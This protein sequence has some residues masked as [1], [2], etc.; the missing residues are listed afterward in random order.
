MRGKGEQWTG[1]VR[2]CAERRAEWGRGPGRSLTK[3]ASRCKRSGDSA[4]PLDSHKLLSCA[5]QWA[6]KVP[7]GRLGLHEKIMGMCGSDLGGIARACQFEASGWQASKRLPARKQIRPS[8]CA[9]CRLV[10]DHLEYAVRTSRWADM[11]DRGLRSK[12]L[13]FEAWLDDLCQQGYNRHEGD[14]TEGPARTVHAVCASLFDEHGDEI[15]QATLAWAA[16]G[17]HLAA[18]SNDTA[19]ATA[20]DTS[21]SQ[22]RPL[23][24]RICLDFS[25][26]CDDAA[27]AQPPAWENVAG[28]G[29]D[30]IPAVVTDE[31]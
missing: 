8:P 19:T 2:L 26:L 21:S 18:A 1:N 23:L 11:T 20:T 28:T 16:A 3:Q 17:L 29:R 30:A 15:T 24:R 14:A 22:P 7:N 5:K 25:G 6:D 12:A 13:D 9:A 31:L 4:T 10:V 27:L